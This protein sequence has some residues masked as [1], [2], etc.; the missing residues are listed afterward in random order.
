MLMSFGKKANVV[1][2]RAGDKARAGEETH[3]ALA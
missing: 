1:L 3:P 2:S